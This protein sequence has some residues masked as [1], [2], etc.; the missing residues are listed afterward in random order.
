MAKHQSKDV[1]GRESLL[2]IGYTEC[3]SC[4]KLVR[5][6]SL[7]CDE[8]GRLMSKGRRIVVLIVA[9]VVLS[10]SIIIYLNMDGE[11]PAVT[12]ELPKV[13]YVDPTGSSV[14]LSSVIMMWFNA[15]MN[16]NSVESAFSIS[17]NVKGSF[18]WTG[19]VLYFTPSVLLST[20]TKYVVT[21][22]PAAADKQGR[23][24]DSNAYCWS[25]TTTGE[26]PPPPTTPT[27][28]TVGF[29]SE[30]FWVTYPTSH[31]LS[32]GSVNHPSWVDTALDSKIVLI[33]DHSV[34]CAPCVQMTAICEA[35]APGH[36]SEMAYFDLISGTTEPQ[37]SDVFA[38]YDPT[39]GVNYIPL[40]V[41]VTV[42][43]DL[44]G[45]IAIG[46]HG[47]EGVLDQVTLESWISDALSYYEENT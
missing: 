16:K 26:S 1:T 8:C 17:P 25:F 32:G 34:G 4:S 10:S 30:N 19:K 5:P 40:T 6:G 21:V 47:W 41:I 29:G 46:W 3:P 38:A 14:S 33:L 15:D 43:K 24:L 13:D 2:G 23:C 11:E 31:P 22:G 7:R 35:V 44:S 18:S 42:V 39:G 28:R 37:A 27:R 20:G 9:M 36:S 12:T 45:N